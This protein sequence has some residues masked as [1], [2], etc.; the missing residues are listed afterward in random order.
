[1]QANGYQYHRYLWQNLHVWNIFEDDGIKATIV[2][3]F[4]YI[5]MSTYTI[6]IYGK[7]YNVEYFCN[8]CRETTIYIKFKHRLKSKKDHA[9]LCQNLHEDEGF[10]T[11]I[12]IKYKYKPMCIN[13][14]DIDLH[15]CNIF[16]HEG[17]K[18]KIDINN[19]Y[20]PFSK[21]TIDTCGKTYVKTYMT[22]K[23]LKQ[24]I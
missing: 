15:I 3:K 9:Y 5:S 22:M 19:K 23:V 20:K 14:I 8:E 13:T 18:T 24:T 6:D 11:T 17:L 10:I 12:D 2:I 1:M 7:T 16:E 4:K 21:N